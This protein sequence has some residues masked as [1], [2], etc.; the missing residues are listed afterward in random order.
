MHGGRERASRSR[1]KT[2]FA[3]I[4][5]GKSTDGSSARKD[6]LPALSES[7]RTHARVHA[8]RQD[9]LQGFRA[10]T[11]SKKVRKP[12][13]TSRSR[14]KTRVEIKLTR[15]GRAE[16]VLRRRERRLLLR[17]RLR[18]GLRRR[19]LPQRSAKIPGR[20]NWAR[21]TTQANSVPPQG[22]LEESAAVVG[23]I[24]PGHGAVRGDRRPSER[25]LHS[26]PRCEASAPRRKSSALIRKCRQ[27]N[28]C[29]AKR[30]L[31]CV[32]F[33][34]DTLKALEAGLP[35]ASVGAGGF[36]FKSKELDNRIGDN[37]EA[38]AHAFRTRIALPV[39]CLYTPLSAAAFKR[40]LR[41]VSRKKVKKPPAETKRTVVETA[42]IGCAFKE[43]R[44]TCWSLGLSALH[45]LLA[46]RNA[47]Q[48]RG[49]A[50]APRLR[51]P[52]AREA[53]PSERRKDLLGP[54]LKGLFFQKERTPESESA[55]SLFCGEVADKAAQLQ[56][57]SRDGRRRGAAKKKRQRPSSV[58]LS[59][60]PTCVGEQ[61]QTKLTRRISRLDRRCRCSSP[62]RPER[63]NTRV[64]LPTKRAAEAA[65][66]TERSGAEALV[67]TAKDCRQHRGAPG[68]NTVKR[69]CHSKS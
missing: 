67:E 54:R 11:P 64:A 65:A 37:A 56:P 13:D 46:R 21:K 61:I 55:V 29:A 50:E 32:I 22:N 43:K 53:S 27:G 69:Q 4:A 3:D 33:P 51:P 35:V 68:S 15:H 23:W 25:R 20:L 58:C 10:A 19:R 44:A 40:S 42:Q 52:A 39:Q 59:S 7:S 48:R 17:F 1:R 49:S 47:L 26:R 34:R 12:V 41:E 18:P 16:R 8:E 63:I 45:L 36:S 2:S 5:M 28:A 62:Q 30:Q 9:S 6:E 66:A 38:R 14:M 60:V 31:R 24:R 57:E